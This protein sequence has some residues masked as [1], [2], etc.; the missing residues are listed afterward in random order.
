MS[1]AIELLNLFKENH[2]RLT[3]SQITDAWSL[4]GVKYTNRIS[5][6]RKM[7]LLII[8]RKDKSVK[9]GTVYHLIEKDENNNFLSI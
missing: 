5:E 7:G 4:V 2:G 8:C 9:G 6:L 1:Q 3:L